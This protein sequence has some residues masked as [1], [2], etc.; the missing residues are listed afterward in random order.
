MYCVRRLHRLG[1]VFSHLLHCQ[2]F[3]PIPDV[4]R[5]SSWPLEA[6][7]TPPLPPTDHQRRK[8]SALR[9]CVFTD[10]FLLF[11][12]SFT[13]PLMEGGG[14]T[15]GKC[16]STGWLCTAAQRSVSFSWRVKEKHSLLSS[17]KNPFQKQ[18]VRKPQTQ[19]LSV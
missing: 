3:L 13:K 14:R 5:L 1:I 9:L 17:E 8:S 4:P 2:T 10:A 11:S 6:E 18:M 19:E 7:V 16:R 15:Q 12:A